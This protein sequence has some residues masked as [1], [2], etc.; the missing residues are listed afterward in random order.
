MSSP[1]RHL[2]ESYVLC[3]I[4][5]LPEGRRATSARVVHQLWGPGEPGQTWTDQLR[6]QFGLQPEV[7]A[8]LASMWNQACAQSRGAGM[9]LTSAEFA[10]WV[11]DEN[12]SDILEMVR[13]ELDPDSG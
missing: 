9:E 11:V 8:Q 1:I 2:L 6:D 5:A 4:G 13:T 10:N 12:F 3:A 7:D